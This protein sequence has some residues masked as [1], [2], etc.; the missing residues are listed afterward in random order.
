MDQPKC[1]LLEP[2][3]KKDVIKLLVKL[4]KEARLI[5]GGTDIL[6]DIRSG[7]ISPRHLI[8]LYNVNM[9]LNQLKEL[10]EDEVATC[11][12]IVNQISPLAVPKMEFEPRHLVWFRH[13]MLVKKL[14]DAFPNVKPEG[15]CV[16]SSLL[17]KL[18]VQHEIKYEHPPAI[19][20]SITTSPSSILCS[21]I[22]SSLL[23]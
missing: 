8:S 13:D 18:G 15:H 22:G 1:E 2:T 17:K 14:L 12:Y 7:A 21:R 20:T 5:A 4:G 23:I 9:T 3:D 10:T 16:F 6:I 19:P 11:L